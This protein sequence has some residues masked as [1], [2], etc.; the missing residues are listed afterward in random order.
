VDGKA[1]FSGAQGAALILTNGEQAVAVAGQAP[2]RTPG[3][4]ANN[5]LQWCFYY[6]GVLDLRDLPL[7]PAEETTLAASLQAYR[8]GDLL[9]A[10]RLYPPGRPPASDAERL[11]HAALLL[12]V[13]QV[14]QTEAELAPL[15][16]GP[17]TDR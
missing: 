2:A 6:P 11:Y 1:S 14:D 17:A 10:L 4:I 12:S 16:A 15:P 13:G 3:F 7:T 8:R 9:A 5:V